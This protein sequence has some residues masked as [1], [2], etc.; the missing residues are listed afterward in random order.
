MYLG[1]TEVLYN[2]PASGGSLASLLG[3]RGFRSG[4]SD[5]TGKT[6][7]TESGTWRCVAT[8]NYG[9][10]TTSGQNGTT[11]HLSIAGLFQ[12]VS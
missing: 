3:F 1:V 2:V 5:V 8:A 10:F 9:S 6:R 12:R 7:A 11:F 4:T